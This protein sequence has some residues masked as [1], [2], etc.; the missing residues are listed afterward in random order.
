MIRWS[1]ICAVIFSLALPAGA[2]AAD[3]A[4]RAPSQA[5]KILI[6]LTKLPPG[7]RMKRLIE[8]ARKEG[9]LVWY[10][11]DREDLTNLRT[12]HSLGCHDRPPFDGGES[13]QISSGRC[14]DQIAA[15]TGDA[16]R[17]SVGEIHRD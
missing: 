2:W 10:A 15:G 8:G 16:P 5:E 12:A 13:G 6:E 4:K 14:L 11:P 7:E 1:W 17:G 3:A 9:T